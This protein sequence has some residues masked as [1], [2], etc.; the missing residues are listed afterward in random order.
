MAAKSPRLLSTT[1]QALGIFLFPESGAEGSRLVSPKGGFGG[2]R[3]EFGD[4]PGRT[5]RLENSEKH[6]VLAM[7]GLNEASG[8]EVVR[9][10]WEACRLVSPKGGG[11]GSESIVIVNFRKIQKI[12]KNNHWKRSSRSALANKD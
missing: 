12:D 4:G 6:K 3:V 2:V 7:S 9:R 1:R 10:C 8:L 5:H 11:S